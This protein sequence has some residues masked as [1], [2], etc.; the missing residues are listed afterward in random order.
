MGLL[1]KILYCILKRH[2]KQSTQETQRTKTVIRHHVLLII[3]I[4]GKK[5]IFFPS[6]DRHFN[7]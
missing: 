6:H 4:H 2:A 7:I 5:N 1:S 3:Q